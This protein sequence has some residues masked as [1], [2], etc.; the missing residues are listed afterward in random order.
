MNMFK[1][2]D[3]VRGSGDNNNDFSIEYKPPPN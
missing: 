2:G 3:R 1:V